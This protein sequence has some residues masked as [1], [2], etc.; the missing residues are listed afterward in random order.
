MGNS[1]WGVLF[2]GCELKKWSAFLKKEALCFSVFPCFLRKK[3][4][5]IL[6]GI[7]KNQ[8]IYYN[9]NI[10]FLSLK[11]ASEKRCFTIG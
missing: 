1:F 3:T 11:N 7:D 6:L 8:K 2:G 5:K 10:V 9:I 4:L